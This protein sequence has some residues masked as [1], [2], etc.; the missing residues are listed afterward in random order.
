MDRNDPPGPADP[1]NTDNP[2]RPSIRLTGT[3]QSEHDALA[4]LFLGDAPFAP[5]PMKTGESRERPAEPPAARGRYEGSAVRAE[6][7]APLDEM[8]SDERPVT[9]LVILGHLPVRASLW[10]RHYACLSARKRSETVSL[11]RAAGGS[12]SI[13]V[14]TGHEPAEIEPVESIQDGVTIARSASTRVILRV[15]ETVEPEL[16]EREG[17]DEVTILTGADEAAVVA[18]Y[19]LIKTLV[20]GLD[21]RLDPEAAPLVRVA[22]M[23]NPGPEIAAACAKIE[24]AC[25]AFLDRPVEV[26][27]ASGRIDATGTVTVCRTDAPHAT[28]EVL[29]ALLDRPTLAG[30]PAA[31]LRLADDDH[32]DDADAVAMPEVVVMPG[33]G[34]VARPASEAIEAPAE[35]PP[36]VEDRIIEP[37]FR[38]GEPLACLIEGLDPI[39]ARCPGA[40][41]VELARDH[42]G[43]LHAV[44][45]DDRGAGDAVASL[46]AACAWARA[47]LSLL[48]RAEAGI[49]IPAADRYEDSDAVLHLLARRPS[50][51]RAV[52]DTQVRVYALASVIL[53]GEE[54]MVATPLNEG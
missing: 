2:T 51:A 33:V 53:D 26:L 38:L 1:R 43:R 15:D 49:T 27:D 41:G 11:V 30:A 32:R 54:I 16:L 50:A 40:P 25:L 5:P 39:E 9:E 13:D 35:E 31:S 14:I 37:K 12:V 22:V 3:E 48:I 10:V 23:G 42:E 19:R 29:D 8:G 47:N 6:R 18:S 7:A 24:R 44:A 28:D 36:P 17:V 46:L 4:E 45:T 34:R 52:L 21:D 20:A